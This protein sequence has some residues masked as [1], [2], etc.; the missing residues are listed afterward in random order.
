M[1]SANSCPSSQQQIKNTYWFKT[2]NSKA[3]FPPLPNLRTAS[4]TEEGWPWAAG[5]GQRA[6]KSDCYSWRFYRFPWARQLT[7]WSTFSMEVRPSSSFCIHNVSNSE[8]GIVGARMTACT[9]YYLVCLLC[10]AAGCMIAA[11]NAA[12]NKAGT[13]HTTGVWGK[14]VSGCCHDQPHWSVSLYVK[15]T[16]R[17]ME[18]KIHS[19]TE[20]HLLKYLNTCYLRS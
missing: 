1:C 7:L 3:C 6:R 20:N 12:S 15:W 14:N 18:I 5:T 8:N 13:S 2:Q 9:F 11:D 10:Q 4:C 16:M 19:Q 17:F